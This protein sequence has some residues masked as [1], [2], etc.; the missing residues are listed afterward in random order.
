MHSYVQGRV[1]MLYWQASG[2]LPVGMN[3]T[4]LTRV[5]STGRWYLGPAV[6]ANPTGSW[7]SEVE[8]G[9]PVPQLK[10]RQ[11]TI[12]VYLLPT[13]TIDRL[14][15]RLASYMATACRSKS[16][17]PDRTELACVAAVRLANS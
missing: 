12:C 9:N 1:L 14:S 6:V 16:F 3:Y 4:S 7:T 11:F 15:Q 5:E 8:I 2:D 13:V 10:N 17:P